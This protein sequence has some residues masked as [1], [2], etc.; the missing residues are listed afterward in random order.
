M[1][2]DGVN[3]VGQMYMACRKVDNWEEVTFRYCC[4]D[5]GSVL[6]SPM[7]QKCIVQSTVQAGGMNL[8]SCWQLFNVSELYVPFLTL[9]F[10]HNW[11]QLFVQTILFFL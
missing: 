2:H 10:T 7:D 4:L 5:L 6:V 9:W 8:A 11:E 1:R 3:P